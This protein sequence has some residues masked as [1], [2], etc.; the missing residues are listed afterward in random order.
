MVSM[1]GAFLRYAWQTE[2]GIVYDS[3]DSDFA[4]CRRNANSPS[5]CVLMIGEH[6]NLAFDSADS[7]TQQ[8][9]GRV[10]GGG[11]VLLRSNPTF[12]TAKR[13]VDDVRL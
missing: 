9:I 6:S 2:Q 10:E 5:G 11:E 8:R 7:G 1:P 3:A 13:L 12:A 4:E